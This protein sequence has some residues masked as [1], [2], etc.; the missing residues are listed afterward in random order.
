MQAAYAF[1]EKAFEDSRERLYER[2]VKI[3]SEAATTSTEVVS[4]NVRVI[5]H[6]TTEWP[7]A[8]IVRLPGAHTQTIFEPVS[9]HHNSVAHAAMKFHDIALLGH[10]APARV[11]V[12]HKKQEFGTYLQVLAQS[13]NVID[14]AVPDFTIVKLAKAA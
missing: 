6:S 14:D 13:A 7:I 8:T 3:F 9:K 12:V 11:A 10:D 1:A 5:G 2:L 4:K